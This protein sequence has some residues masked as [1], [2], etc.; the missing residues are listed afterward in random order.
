MIM[1]TVSTF[2]L[3]LWNLYVPK[4]S[5]ESFKNRLVCLLAVSYISVYKLPRKCLVNYFRAKGSDMVIDSDEVIMNN[6]EVL[7]QLTEA[8]GSSKRNG[9]TAG[10]LR[11]CQTDVH[12][13]NYKYSIGSF[14]INYLIH[15]ESIEI[16]IKSGYHFQLN[17]DRLTRHLH[18]WFHL[19]TTKGHAK[20]FEIKGNSWTTSFPELLAAKK[21]KKA[22]RQPKLSLL[23]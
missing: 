1:K 14:T 12:K 9:S 19:L 17:P 2:D 20:S 5:E 21:K 16:S 3:Y 13:P 15:D 23:I 6:Q 11:I 10:S 22:E 18:S 8:I 4:L 7:N